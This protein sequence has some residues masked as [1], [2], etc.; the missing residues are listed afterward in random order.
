MRQHG[1]TLIELMIVVVIIGILA[2][3][4]IPNF[5]T[6]QQRAKEAAVKANMHSIHVTIEDFNTQ[7]Q[8]VY[9]MN[10]AVTVS[11]ANPGVLNNT[12]TVAGAVS[13]M[14]SV[15]PCILPTS[16]RNPIHK[17]NGLCFF[18]GPAAFAAAPPAILAVPAG[19]AGD[20]GSVWYGSA[21]AAGNAAAVGNANKYRIYGYGLHQMMPLPLT[22]GS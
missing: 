6:M 16:V 2:A 22:S 5:M 18:S 15:A 3:I 14:Q 13:G 12:A 7:A 20:P 10:F 21:D 9:P 11:A 4:A 17:T 1:F 8:G 19:A